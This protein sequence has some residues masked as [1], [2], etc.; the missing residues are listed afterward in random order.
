[1]RKSKIQSVPKNMKS[2]LE[3]SPDNEVL[4][5]FS[6]ETPRAPAA[7]QGET[8]ESLTHLDKIS[9]SS[10]SDS[11]EEKLQTV[12]NIRCEHCQQPEKPPVAS[13]QIAN[14]VDPQ[15]VLCCQKARNRDPAMRKDQR[16]NLSPWG[17]TYCSDTGGLKK[18]W[19]WLD[20]EQ[21]VHAPPYRTL[22]LTLSPNLNIRIQSQEHICIAFTSGKRR[23]QLNVGA[24]LKLN[25][26][27]GLTL[28]G[29]DMLQRYL[30][31][32]SA[33]INALLQNIQSLIPDQKTV[34]PRKVKPQ[35]SLISQTER[36]QLPMKQQQ[37]AKKTPKADDG[38]CVK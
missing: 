5:L 10:G 38:L 32:K 1:M 7:C 14:S 13:H 26:G 6:E 35:P 11:S 2:E 8:E 36:R 34:S 15:E 3:I 18:H 37:S 16:V 4:D 20:K 21:H 28:P 30:Q 31:Q 24:K 19:D 9:S 17:G 25:Q 22:A 33:E 27:K 23:V 29:L 12:L